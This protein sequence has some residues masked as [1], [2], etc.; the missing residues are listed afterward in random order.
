ML[1][2]RLLEQLGFNLTPP[3]SL[4]DAFGSFLLSL[5][6]PRGTLWALLGHPWAALGS[7]LVPL[8]R[9]FPTLGLQHSGR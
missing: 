9:L 2:R 6:C 8:G 5:G 1:F 3:G 4:F 7:L